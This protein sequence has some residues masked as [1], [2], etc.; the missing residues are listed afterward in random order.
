MDI[1]IM[2]VVVTVAEFI[3]YTLAAPFDD[4]HQMMLTK[5]CQRP[6]DIRLVDGQNP[7][8]QFCERHRPQ[9][10]SQLSHH[11]DAVGRWLDAVFLQQLYTVCFVQGCKDTKYL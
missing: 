1:L 9:A 2:I 5:E 8:F 3:P 11:D 6:K 7:A 10:F 4:M